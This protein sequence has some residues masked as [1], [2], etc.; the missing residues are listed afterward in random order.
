M[1]VVIPKR[2]Q[3]RPTDS[4]G[5]VI[6][7]TVFIDADGAPHFRVPDSRKLITCLKLKLCGICGN[8]LE[9]WNT[10]IGSPS[11]IEQ[12]LFTDPAMHEECARYAL[13]ACPFLANKNYKSRPVDPIP[14][15]VMIKNPASSFRSEKIALVFFKKYEQCVVTGKGDPVPGMRVAKYHRIEWF[16]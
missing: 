6:P 11:E 1:S 2:L 12:H 16:D 3:K 13:A 9:G 15:M 7:Y 10:A 4:R 14:G 5:Y 8:E